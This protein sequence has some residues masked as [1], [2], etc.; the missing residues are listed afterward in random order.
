MFPF[1]PTQCLSLQQQEYKCKGLC[2]RSSHPPTL[3]GSRN[4]TT[5]PRCYQGCLGSCGNSP[6][7]LRMIPRQITNISLG[8]I[9]ATGEETFGVFRMLTKFF[10]WK[11]PIHVINRVQTEQVSYDRFILNQVGTCWISPFISPIFLPSFLP[12]TKK[13]LVKKK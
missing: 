4:M 5:F 13:P 10:I 7:S 3:S 1:L 6:R 8:S 9:N 2:L 12:P 11:S